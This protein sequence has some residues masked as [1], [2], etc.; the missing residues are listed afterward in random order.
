MNE[1]GLQHYGTG[2]RK[3]SSARVY[4]R[5][6]NGGF[7]VNGRPFDDYFSS[8]LPAVH[9]YEETVQILQDHYIRVASFAAHIGGPMSDQDVEPGFFTDYNSMPA[10][11]AATS[12]GVFDIDDVYNSTI[13]LTEAINEFV[14]EE[15]CEDYIPE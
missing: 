7:T 15:L 10:I 2:R 4:L 12:G 1:Q 11:P 13:S 8:G 9:T 5:P 6:G 14:L 3:T